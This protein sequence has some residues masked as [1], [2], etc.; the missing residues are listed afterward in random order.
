MKPKQQ[1]FVDEY[2]ID[3]NGK[4]AAI[5]AGYS[6]RRAQP[7]ACDLLKLPDVAAAVAEGLAKLADRNGLSADWVLSE[8]QENH[9]LARSEGEYA[10]SNK[11]LELLG[12][13]IGMF[14]DQLEHSGAIGT[15]ESQPI[16]REHRNSDSLA[17]AAGSA[18]NGDSSRHH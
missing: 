14:K 2:L 5:R 15:Y 1:R 4:A 11:A 7:T 6:V 17:G 10:A 16:E 8:L 12:K 9:R 3:Q 13:H 18:A